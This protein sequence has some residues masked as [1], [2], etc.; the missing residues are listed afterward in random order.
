M[1]LATEKIIG[2]L[3]CFQW[4]LLTLSCGPFSVPPPLGEILAT[5]LIEMFKTSEG[6]DW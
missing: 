1:R 2:A 4:A 3:F 6:T 5:S